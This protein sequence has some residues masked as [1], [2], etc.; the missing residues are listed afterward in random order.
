MLM[1]EYSYET[2]IEV[3]R[4]ETAEEAAK[5]AAEKAEKE[6]EDRKFLE[7]VE[8]VSRNFQIPVEEACR[9]LEESYERYLEIKNNPG[10][11]DKTSE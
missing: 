10:Y 1:A 6:T 8:K 9:K 7:Y 5:K 11:N 4:Q 3:Q 2:D